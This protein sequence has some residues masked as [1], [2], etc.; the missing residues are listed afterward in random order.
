MSML[1]E[2]KSVRK[3]AGISQAEPAEDEEGQFFF[4]FGAAVLG[5]FLHGWCEWVIDECIR[6]NRYE[7][8]PLMREA[9]LL[10]PILEE[11]ARMRGVALNVKPLYV[12]RQATYLASLDNYGAEALD[13][14]LQINWVTVGDLFHM[15]DIAEETAYFHSYL[16][17]PLVQCSSTPDKSGRTTIF[18]LLREFLLEDR[19]QRKVEASIQRNR[20]L[21]VDYLFQECGSPESVMTVDIGFNGTIQKAMEMAMRLSNQPHRMIHLLAV[22]TENVGTH[23]LAGM[24]VRCFLGSCGDNSDIGS[25]I[26]RT[27]AFLEELMMG[28]FGSTLHRVIDMPTPQGMVTRKSPYYLYK[29]FLRLQDLIGHQSLIFEL[30]RKV[31][32]DGVSTVH[33]YGRGSFAESV[34]KS[35]LLHGL[36][37]ESS[38]NPYA[39]NP[40]N[41]NYV[42]ASLSDIS[43]FRQQIEQKYVNSGISP[44]IYDLSFN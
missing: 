14:L 25:R 7:V 36:S 23:L 38:M 10:A 31:K 1:P 15:L 39:V 33:I 20:K 44:V 3:L 26:A 5:P 30:I 19:I 27:P 12:S 2:L 29:Y 17:T 40:G 6:E 42:I 37:V 28:E 32:E 9:Y 8:H 34:R 22:G 11:A 21:F 16:D 18:G 41:P 43:T 4:S 24:D 13:R 35:A